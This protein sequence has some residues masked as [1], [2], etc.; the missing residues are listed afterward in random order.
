M[1]G[2]EYDA[3]SISGLTLESA[4]G[5][6]DRAPIRTFWS[7]PGYS[8]C[9]FTVQGNLDPGLFHD[10][11]RAF[12]SVDPGDPDGKALLEAEACTSIV[13]GTEQGWDMVERA[14]EDEG[15]I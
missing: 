13:A 12:L 10:I 6:S 5:R 2:G 3:G 1:A 9:C 15:L 4:L 14:A 7:S 8:H 11:E